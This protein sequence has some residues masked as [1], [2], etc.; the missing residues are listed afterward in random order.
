MLLLDRGPRR[1]RLRLRGSLV[2]YGNLNL[3]RRLWLRGDGRRRCLLW[4]RLL[5]GLVRLLLGRCCLMGLVCLVGLM[6]LV[7]LVTDV[8]RLVGHRLVS[9]GLVDLMGCRRRRRLMLLRLVGNMALWCLM[10]RV[11]RMA[12]VSLM[13]EGL[14]CLM[15]WLLMGLVR[16]VC[17]VGH[18]AL[19]VH[20]LGHLVLAVHHRGRLLPGRGGALPRLDDGARDVALRPSCGRV[21]DIAVHAGLVEEVMGVCRLRGLLGRVGLLLLVGRGGVRDGRSLVLG[22]S[23]VRLEGASSHAADLGERQARMG[24]RSRL[25]QGRHDGGGRVAASRESGRLTRAG[26][27]DDKEDE[28]ETLMSL[29]RFGNPSDGLMMGIAVRR[30]RTGNPRG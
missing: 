14:V 4:P 7:S 20:R 15:R 8:L 12:G 24:G 22:G 2:L 26:K 23:V 10:G 9:G 13:L 5:L 18:D 25:P 29:L 21:G 6:G 19:A 30:A 11:A 1:L 3:L 16:L 17:L 27:G 28:R